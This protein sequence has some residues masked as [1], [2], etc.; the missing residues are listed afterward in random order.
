MTFNMRP[1]SCRPTKHADWK[2]QGGSSRCLGGGRVGEANALEVEPAGLAGSV[3]WA[4]QVSLGR[5]LA[6]WVHLRPRVS[7][8][9][10]GTKWGTRGEMMWNRPQSSCEPQQEWSLRWKYNT[11]SRLHGWGSPRPQAD[12]LKKSSVSSVQSLM[13]RPR[14]RQHLTGEDVASTQKAHERARTTKKSTFQ[15]IQ[16]R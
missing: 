1:G 12:Y 15:N 11:T 5:G 3:E 14:A 6:W 13:G 7:H 16:P 10:A 9:V 8:R 4:G 2:I